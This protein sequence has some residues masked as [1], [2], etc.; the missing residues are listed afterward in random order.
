VDGKVYLITNNR[1]SKAYIGI[2]RRTTDYR[3]SMH[4]R[5]AE[6]GKGSTASLQQ[7]IREFGQS[8]FSIRLLA[9]AKTIRAGVSRVQYPLP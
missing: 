1:N 4:V 8:A 6:A 2:T 7:A 5:A 3:M 9:T